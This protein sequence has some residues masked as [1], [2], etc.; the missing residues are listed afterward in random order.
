[1]SEK[2]WIRGNCGIESKKTLRKEPANSSTTIKNERKEKQNTKKRRESIKE[3]DLFFSWLAIIN[4]VEVCHR[5]STT[6]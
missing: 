3:N 2:R 1:M 4:S 5:V 6:S